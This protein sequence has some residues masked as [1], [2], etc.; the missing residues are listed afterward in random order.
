MVAFAVLVSPARAQLDFERPPIDYLRAPH[1]D[2]VAR[3]AERL[4][5]DGKLSPD[6]RRGYLPALLRELGIS[7]KSQVL[8]FS[9]TSF[10][11]SKIGP[12]RP[13]ALYFDDDSYVGW[14]QQGD[15]LEIASVA[16]RAGVMFYTLDQQ[17]AERPRLVRQNQECLQCHA[18]PMTAGIPG[19]MVRSVF[20]AGSGNPILSAGTFLTTW[21]SPL[22]ERWGGWYVTGTHG[23][24]R[25]MGNAILRGSDDPAKLDR[26]SGA[27]LIDLSRRFDPSPYL[28]P[29][30]DI[31]ALLVLEH[32]AAAHTQIALAG[33][34]GLLAR[35]EQEVLNQMSGKPAG[36][37]IESIDRRYQWAADDVLKCL[38]FAGEAPLVEP[39]QGTSGFAE[40]F[41]ALGPR[42]QHGRS[43]RQFDFKKRLFRYPCSYLIYSA[44]FDGL[45]DEVRTRVYRSLERILTGQDASPQFAHLSPDDRQAIREILL[46]TKPELAESWKGRQ[47]EE[48][49]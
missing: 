23:R 22:A 19:L 36:E 44:A 29:H 1:D 24:Q 8:V 21:Q 37:R 34:Q 3:L 15:V 11:R 43:L 9:K 31:A 46:D 18:S 10:Q 49:H 35:R 17:P 47:V 13:R 6:P 12:K 48:K 26:E 45:P 30:S 27:N 7:E 4:D 38:L 14:V 2:P 32:Q 40:Y 42:D 25:H 16:P 39:V 20:P 33:Y 5:D 28:T 41:A